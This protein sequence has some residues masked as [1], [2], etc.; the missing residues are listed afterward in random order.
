[1]ADQHKH[2]LNRFHD[3]MSKRFIMVVIVAVSAGLT[4]FGLMSF[5]KRSKPYYCAGPTFD[6][7]CSDYFIW[8]SVGSQLF[9][10]YSILITIFVSLSALFLFLYIIRDE[11]LFSKL[12]NMAMTWPLFSLMGYI[13]LN[14]FSLI[15]IPV[16]LALSILAMINS[17]E[18]QQSNLDWISMPYNLI[19][20]FIFS[21]FLTSYLHLFGE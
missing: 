15:L 1:M 6:S 11:Y 8:Q 7:P 21:S 20:L 12:G 2:Q 3:P 9:S 17:G 19:W 14:V 10:E 18:N 5:I 16:G 13:F 4:W